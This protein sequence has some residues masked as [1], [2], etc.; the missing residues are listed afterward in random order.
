MGIVIAIV[1]V[2]VHAGGEEIYVIAD[3]RE[4]HALDFHAVG[5]VVGQ[6]VGQGDIAQVEV[7]AAHQ[8]TVVV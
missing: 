3:Q 5:D 2:P 1:E 8:E 4:A 6:S 7:G